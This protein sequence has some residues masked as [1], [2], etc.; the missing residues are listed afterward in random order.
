[1]AYDIGEALDRIEEELIASMIRN[2]GRHRIEEIKEEKEWTMWQAEQL[3]SLRAYRRDNKEKYSGRF[4]AINEKIEE[5]I[6]KSYE[7]GGM[8]EERKILR[9]AKKGAK[10]RQSMNPLTGRFF[11]LNKEK[12]EALIKATK[13]DMTKAETA[14]LRMAD[15]QYRKAIF[16]A[17]VYANSG[18]GTY[19]QAVDMAT[20]SMLSSGL[21]CVE[22]KNGARHTLPNYARMAVRTANKRAYLSGEGEKR[23]KWGITTV[24]LAKRGNP[25]PKCAPFVGKVFIDDVWSGGNKKDGDYPL[26]SSAI[27]AGLYHPNCKDSHTTY[28]PELHAGEE[29]WTKEELE[30]VAEDY[31]REQKEKRIEHQVS[32]FERLSKFSLDPE[33]KKQYARKVEQWKAL[34]SV[35]DGEKEL[36]HIKD[37]GVRDMGHVNLE[38]VNT[39]KYHDKFEGLG[40][41]K[42]VSESIYKEAMEILEARNNTFYEEIVAIDARTGKRLVKNTS[43]VNMCEHSCGF[44]VA[45]EEKLNGWKIPFEVLHNHPNSSFPSRDDIKKLFD[46]EWQIGSTISCHDGTVYRIEKLKPMENIDEYIQ[47]MYNKTKREMIG[48]SDAAIEE[49]TS[50]AVIEELQKSKHLNFLER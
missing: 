24:I 10:L 12:L 33:N 26:L 48:Y 43:A 34:S 36:A 27:G 21:N 42:V 15:D 32:K 20:K 45:E 28:F 50:K 25:C 8:H 9:A 18:A 17:Q 46:R 35:M 13:A 44:S 1:M 3:K 30:E 4:L 39:K 19:E 23:R 6:R 5:A 11:Q 41:N 2:M 31:N 49:E 22:Y 14:I 29:K 38:L 7:S 37:D 16:N 47:D 40:K